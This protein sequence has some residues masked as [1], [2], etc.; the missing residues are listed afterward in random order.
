MLTP[1][2]YSDYR[3]YLQAVISSQKQTRG[4]QSELAEAAK[5]QKSYFSQVLRTKTNLTPE[6]ALRIAAFLKFDDDQTDYFMILVDIGRTSYPALISRLNQQLKLIVQRRE[7]LARRFNESS[8]V[9]EGSQLYYSSWHWIAVHMAASIPRL[10]NAQAIAEHL[11]LKSSIVD[12]TLRGLK[13]M[14]LVQQD[15]ERWF[16]TPAHFHLP[17]ESP[18]IMTHHAN[19]RAQATLDTQNLDKESLHYT[20]VHSHSRAD[21]HNLKEDLLATIDRHRSVVHRSPEEELS[22]LCMDFFRL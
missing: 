10:Q 12:R 21:F 19:W 3:A 2:G 15:G 11:G 20:V 1:I 18:L 22:C 16:I 14:G 17:K 9:S 8:V 6:Q 4:F 7:H 5:C 13:E